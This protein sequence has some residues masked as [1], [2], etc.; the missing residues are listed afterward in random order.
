MK[1][2]PG[3]GSTDEPAR[4]VHQE[5]RDGGERH[6]EVEEDLLELRNDEDHDTAHDREGEGDDHDRIDHRADDLALQLL[7]L[8]HEVGQTIENHVENPA[9]LTGRHHV[10]VESVERLGVLAERF[11]Q[12]SAALDILGDT[13]QHILERAGPLLLFENVQTSKNRQSRILKRR[14]LPR[15]RGQLFESNPTEGEVHPRFFLRARRLGLGSALFAKPR[16]EVTERSD[17]REGVLAG[18]RVN[19]VLDLLARLVH[20]FICKRRHVATLGTDSARR[21]VSA[22]STLQQAAIRKRTKPQAS[23][24]SSRIVSRT[25]SSIVVIPS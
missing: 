25:T 23:S 8:F 5:D 11:G 10:D 17:L 16:R 24:H 2:Q 13:A 9:R 12:R 6:V 21:M 18:C 3:G 14:K 19:L 1:T 7:R 20:R 4:N 15:E 22:V